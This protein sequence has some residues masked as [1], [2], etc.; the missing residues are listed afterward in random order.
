METLKN[1][2]NKIKEFIEHN[3]RYSYVKETLSFKK[4]RLFGN[5]TIILLTIIVMFI[6]I[7]VLQHKQTQHHKEIAT[8]HLAT[9]EKLESEISDKKY[10]DGEVELYT[11]IGI[12]VLERN[13][14]MCTKNNIC[15]YIDY[16]AEMDVV[17]YPEVMK[18]ICQI[19][20]DFGK[21]NVA[22]KYNNL[23]GMDHPRRRKTLSLYSSGRFATF[24]N[25]KCSILDMA[26]WDYETFKGKIPIKEE[27]YEKINSK[28]NTE[29]PQYRNIILEAEKNHK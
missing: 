20:S 22:K 16:L 18:A 13:C 14:G 24:K 23:F 21:S 10:I 15:E 11:E 9:I 17:W 26:L 6:L 3:R 2:Y 8:K 27:Y 7:S 4:E 5:I 19:E 25:W 1:I 28:Y 29:N 12:V